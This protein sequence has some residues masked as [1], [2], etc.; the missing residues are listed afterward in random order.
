MDGRCGGLVVRVSR[1]FRGPEGRDAGQ[2]LCTCIRAGTPAARMARRPGNAGQFSRWGLHTG[3]APR[4]GARARTSQ[5]R[6]RACLGTSPTGRNPHDRVRLHS[7][8]V[9][10]RRGPRVGRSGEQSRQSGL[11]EG[12][13]LTSA[14]CSVIGA[15]FALPRDAGRRPAFQAVPAL[16]L[17]RRCAVSPGVPGPAVPYSVTRSWPG[18][19]RRVLIISSS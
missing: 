13:E 4:S 7:P 1:A 2:L 6:D 17:D 8:P 18:I 14:W 3:T 15:G 12:G 16:L 10:K 9:M 5:F 19:T 11:G